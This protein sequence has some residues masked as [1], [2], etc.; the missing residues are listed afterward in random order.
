MTDRRFEFQRRILRRVTRTTPTD[1]V[2]R[3]RL[4][5]IDASQLQQVADRFRA[6]ET[7]DETEQNIP[8]LYHHPRTAACDPVVNDRPEQTD[9]PHWT[10]L[11][12]QAAQDTLEA[13]CKATGRVRVQFR[14]RVQ[15]IWQRLPSLRRF[16]PDESSC[17]GR[18]Y[19]AR[20]GIRAFFCDS[21]I[22]RGSISAESGIA[23]T[24]TRPL[25]KT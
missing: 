5:H 3:S 24:A 17:G 10:E 12:E 11:N 16:D 4:Q 6:G 2:A 9:H 1:L 21:V 23:G 18:F 13:V 15:T 25:R 20:A 7:L 22:W 14:C 8:L 19:N